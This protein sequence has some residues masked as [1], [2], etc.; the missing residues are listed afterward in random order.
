VKFGY[1]VVRLLLEV[2]QI[3]VHGD[4]DLDAIASS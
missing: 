4:I 3:L 2:E 1:H